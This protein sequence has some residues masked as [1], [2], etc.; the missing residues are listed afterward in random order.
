MFTYSSFSS[1]LH[2]EGLLVVKNDS[3][4]DTYQLCLSEVFLPPEI[5]AHG[6][7]D[8]QSIVRIHKHMDKAIQSGSKEAYKIH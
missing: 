1:L 3:K 8:W 4:T 7:D 5:F 6:R 2:F